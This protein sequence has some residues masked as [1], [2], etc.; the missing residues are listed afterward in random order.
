MFPIIYLYDR[1]ALSILLQEVSCS[2]HD[3]RIFYWYRKTIQVFHAQRRLELDKV[4]Q[5]LTIKML[6]LES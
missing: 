6:I 4:L 2:K 1:F 5:K 3:C